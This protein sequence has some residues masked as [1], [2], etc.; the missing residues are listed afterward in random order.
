MIDKILAT[1][2]RYRWLVI[3]VYVV[4]AVFAVRA[5]R[6]TPVDAIPDLSD[7][8]VIVF[9]PYAGRSPTVIE[10]QIT[11]PITSR[12]LA[13][14]KVSAVRGYSMLGMSFVYVVFDEGTDT[15]WARS[16]VLETL[17][18]L[19][20]TLPA[21]VTPTLGPD[22][23]SVGWVYE[24]ALVDH[25]GKRD[26]GELRSLQD[27]TLRYALEAVPGVAQ[28]ATVG[29]Y[30]KEYQVTCDPERLRA[31]GLSIDDVARA[32]KKASGESSGRVIEMSGREHF[33]R[34]RGYLT[35]LASL[36]DVALRV[37]A[38]GNAVRIRD[39]ATVRL[40][41]AIRRG[42]A[43][44][45]GKGETVGAI[46]ISRVD[47]N[48]RAV[49]ARVRDRIKELQRSL[50]EGVEI[51]TTYDRGPF[52]DRA[53]DTLV[54][55]LVE[56]GVTVALVILL[57]LFHF[58]SAALPAISM[59]LAVL[60]SFLPISLL[61][62]TSNIMSLG[63]IAIAIGATVD[64]EIVMIEACHK[65]L[66]DLPETAS[67]ATRMKL[68]HEAAREVTPAIF[69]SLLVI[70]ASF[71]PIFGLK[72]QA[73]RLFIPLAVTKTVLMLTAAVISITLAPALRDLL[74]RG[75]IRREDK[76]PVSRAI[77]HVYEPFVHVALRR[78]LTTVLIGVF[79]VISAVPIYL[80][81][82]TEFMPPLREG[83]LLYM[84]S[85]L[86]NVSIEEAKRQLVHQDAVLAAMP[87]VKRVFG[88]IGRASTPT[89]PAPI[90][91]VETVI[92]LQP[93]AKWPLLRR[94]RWYS[95]WAPEWLKVPLRKV[96]PDRTPETY[97]EL[98]GKLDASLQQPGWTNA[99]TMPIK[100]RLDMLATGVRTAVG[101][102]V[103]GPS[104]PEIDRAGAEI[105]ATLRAIPGARGVIYE[106]TL[107]GAYV[108]VV[109]KRDA[110]AR[111]GL[112]IADVS[113]ALERAVAGEPVGETIDGRQ[114]YAISVRYA[115]DFRSS[116]EALRRVMVEL[117]AMSGGARRLEDAP[118]G[119]AP[120]LVPLGEIADVAIVEGPPMLRSEAG[121]LAG[122]VY[123][124]LPPEVDATRWVE[125]AQQRVEGARRAGTI[126]LSPGS[127]IVWTGEHE[128]VKQ[129]RDRLLVLGP[130]AILIV[131]LL[132]YL[133]F[134]N[135]TEVLIV[136]LSVPF[137]LTGSVWF[138]WLLDY[139]ISTAV[140]V[141]VI[142]L[143]G[144]AT[145]TGVVMI[146]YI[147][148][149]F[150]RRAREGR[151]QT[152]ED[153]VEAHAEGTV[154][155]VRPKLMTVASMIAG[156]VP[157]L[158]A[159]GSGAD[160]MKRIAAPM[161]GGL[162]SSAFLTLEIIPVVYTAWRASQLA[163]AKREGRDLLDVCGLR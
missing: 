99:W 52:I 119:A 50:P 49:I 28:V 80:R 23:T 147:D 20:G 77:R 146:V 93:Q 102:K 158:W 38:V 159:T 27:F 61:G 117:P 69:F 142:A 137:A 83:D 86:P 66:E 79:A 68:L 56:E 85:T 100:T 120:R 153:I 10:D 44:L 53:I 13:S 58:R 103:L 84:P 122:Y 121:M 21:G 155:R 111:A 46:V 161:I 71:V 110:L 8:Q 126:V 112:S 65:K 138:M 33:V 130:L 101:V 123:V 108:D 63:G 64:A 97:E 104:L 82:G 6:T 17:S 131:T 3:F 89:D 139:R 160:V 81:L 163:R 19:G 151:I 75:K 162:I 116:P 35:D 129:T 157:L 48:P 150:A 135:V 125:E 22:A 29:G 41:P 24:Y 12:L 76:H 32:A 42:A 34:G 36:G 156:L 31:Y 91:M 87:E 39:V 54:K 62:M 136:L 11:Y 90:S 70:A 59:P 140:W 109:P 128:L 47:E 26:L 148:Q 1:C 127:Y 114:R 5:V 88:K 37:D 9:T 124:D 105:E 45:D 134:R 92:Q 7:P 67:H 145:Q 118:G 14:P 141:G 143:V 144:L 98:I 60:L 51:V 40:G 25:T 115:E 18:T 74:L 96:W 95:S 15:Y 78:P 4:A 106:R 149:A 55:A 73:G 72:G 133:Q 57:F 30:E 107:G 16:R 152:H 94:P 154:L 113:A 132:L 2:A 43:E